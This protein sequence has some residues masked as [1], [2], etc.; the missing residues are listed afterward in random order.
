MGFIE[1][2]MYVSHVYLT[3]GY[4]TDLVYYQALILI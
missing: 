4:S 3:I 2:L 1:S